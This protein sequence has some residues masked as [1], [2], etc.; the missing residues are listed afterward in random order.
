MQGSNPCPRHPRGLLALGETDVTRV[1]LGSLGRQTG[2]VL[3]TRRSRTISGDL[4]GTKLSL[5][6]RWKPRVIRMVQVR[7]LP[8]RRGGRSYP[9]FITSQKGIKGGWKRYDLTVG[10]DRQTAKLTP[11]GL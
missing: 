8:F 9:L 5:V 1:P 10:K 6:E 11:D 3:I 7:V 4:L 2:L